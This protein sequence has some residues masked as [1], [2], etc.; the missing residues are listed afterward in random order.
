MYDK[1]YT[2]FLL[3]SKSLWPPFSERERL[4]IETVFLKEEVP[5]YRVG[6]LL[7]MK[8][9]G[10]PACVHATLWIQQQHKT[11]AMILKGFCNNQ[12]KADHIPMAH[13]F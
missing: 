13:F 6:D 5:Y 9:V 2:Q 1:K 7:S 8:E 4:M 12:Q 3:K 10:S 11:E